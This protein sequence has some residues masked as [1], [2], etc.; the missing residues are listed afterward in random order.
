M[1]VWKLTWYCAA[2]FEHHY[3]L[4]V[5]GFFKVDLFLQD[6]IREGAGIADTDPV[7]DKGRVALA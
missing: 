1:I 7:N 3:E 6:W 2:C 4:M 5:D